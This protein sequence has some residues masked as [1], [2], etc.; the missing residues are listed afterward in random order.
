MAI[1]PDHVQIRSEDGDLNLIVLLGED[2]PLLSGGVGGWEAVNRPGR[3][4]LT[5]WRGKSDPLKYTIALMF[6]HYA[7]D[8]S[9]ESECRLLEK[10]GGLDRGDPEPP[11]LIIEGA[12]PHDESRA[13]ANR[14]V[15]DTLEWGDA[16]RRNDGHRVRQAVTATLLEFV[17]PDKLA[18]V[19]KASKRGG[20]FVVAHAGDT[21]EKIATR[22][23]GSGRLGRK[24]AQFNGKRSASTAIKAG[25]R[26]KL[27]SAAASADWKRGK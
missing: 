8:E 25:T 3:R 16:I 2:Q 7:S 14:W 17:E 13:K 1:P 19:K 24:L 15:I 10:M 5:A 27:P 21:F 23:L 12:L 4:P 26:V 22:E 11:K 18:R 20:K 6:D 9:V